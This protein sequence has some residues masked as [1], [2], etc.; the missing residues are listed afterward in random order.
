[1]KRIKIV[2]IS[3]IALI[4]MVVL[5]L[6][7][8]RW[9]DVNNFTKEIKTERLSNHAK[10]YKEGPVTNDW[11]KI[12]AAQEQAIKQ[13]IPE[14]A[15]ALLKIPSIGLE[16]PIYLGTNEYTLS[17]GA[18]T[19]L[20]DTLAGEGNFVLAGHSTPYQ[21]VL[22]TDLHKVEKGAK[23]IVEIPDKEFSYIVD[24]VVRSD[25]QFETVNNVP[26]DEILKLPADKEKPKIT[27]FTCV[28]WQNNSERLIV[29]GH[30]V[31]K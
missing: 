4:I 9:L 6:T 19:Y 26:T 1:M 17:L 8:H 14:N 28:S 10:R 30:L 18:A 21:G 15:Y 22:F 3:V 5:G 16:L 13:G 12:K 23:I 24:D 31:E 2:T 11:D 29:G 7:I 25:K 27:L 20:Y